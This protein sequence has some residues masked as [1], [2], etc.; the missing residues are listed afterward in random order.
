MPFN[1]P[2]LTELRERNKAFV[3]S[4][5]REIGALL[6]FSNLRV[7]ADADAGM[8]WLHYGY[9]DWIAKQAVPY[10]ATDEHLAAWGALKG[11]YRKSAVAAVGYA[12]FT[13]NVGATVSAG[14]VLNRS[15]S[16][17]YTLKGNIVIGSNGTAMGAITAVLRDPAENATAGGAEGNADSG[18]LLTLDVAWRGVDSTVTMNTAAAGGTDIEDEDEFR[19]RVLYAYQYPLQGGQKLIMCSGP[20]QYPV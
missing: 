12:M 4:E 2:T 10:T 16:Y 20:H 3:E 11:I 17:Q 7:I 19:S 6:R 5:L 9:L 13:G 1:R 15:D 18:T 14:A 8:A